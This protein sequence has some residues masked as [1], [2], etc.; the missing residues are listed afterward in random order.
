[1]SML[2]FFIPKLWSFKRLYVQKYSL[3]NVN[4]IVSR[5][6]L[7]KSTKVTT[8]RECFVQYLAAMM[9]KNNGNIIF[10]YHWYSLFF[11]YRLL[12]FCTLHFLFSS[13]DLCK[14]PLINTIDFI[15][16]WVGDTISE[17][18]PKPLSLK[19]SGNTSCACLTYTLDLYK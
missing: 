18:C 4:S 17:E 11:S 7:C 9:V 1:M 14:S 12:H 6:V 5:M 2:S 3:C 10:Y 13:P 19:V 8:D 16:I 15:L